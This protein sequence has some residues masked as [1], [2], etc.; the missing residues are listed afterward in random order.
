MQEKQKAPGKYLEQD[1]RS[2]KAARE[3]AG[4]IGN[5]SAGVQNGVGAQNGIDMQNGADAQNK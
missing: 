2:R 1:A 5:Q 4:E 3:A